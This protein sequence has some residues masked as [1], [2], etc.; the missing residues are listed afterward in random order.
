MTTEMQQKTLD[1]FEK[2]KAYNI[3]S[4]WV[5]PRIV[6]ATYSDETGNL[7]MCV[8]LRSFH[9]FFLTGSCFIIAA[10]T[11]HDGSMTFQIVFRGLR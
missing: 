7:Y 11:N 3:N 5:D 10:L 2:L 4:E 9:Y 8:T 6:D 1:L